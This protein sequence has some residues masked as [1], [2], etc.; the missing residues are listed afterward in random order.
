MSLKNRLGFGWLSTTAKSIQQNSQ[1]VVSLW[2]L[3]GILGASYLENGL[4]LRHRYNTL[5]I[6]QIGNDGLMD[7]GRLKI[8]CGSLILG[9]IEDG[10]QTEPCTFLSVIAEMFTHLCKKGK[11]VMLLHFSLIVTIHVT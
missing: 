4:I 8:K 3:S 5:H 10:A 6:E 11:A 2:V 1:S 7:E 9:F